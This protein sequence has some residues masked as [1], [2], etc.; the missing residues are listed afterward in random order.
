MGALPSA[1][2]LVSHRHHKATASA[3]GP[4]TTRARQAG[5]A[6]VRVGHGEI[7]GRLRCSVAP[8]ASPLFWPCLVSIPI[9]GLAMSRTVAQ[10]PR[11]TLLG[12]AL[13]AA[14]DFARPVTPRVR[15]GEQDMHITLQA[16]RPSVQSVRHP[17]R[18]SFE[19]NASPLWSDVS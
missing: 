4:I 5:P 1:V 7:G 17:P 9:D 18:Q 12:K 19:Q 13:D 11:P 10:A 8:R 6:Q 2:L 3:C 16:R 14:A 15:R